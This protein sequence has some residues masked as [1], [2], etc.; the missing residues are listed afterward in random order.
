MRWII[1]LRHKDFVKPDLMVY[2]APESNL[3]TPCPTNAI[4]LGAFSS[5][6]LPLPTKLNK[7]PGA[8]VLFSLADDE[9][10]DVPNRFNSTLQPT[11]DSWASIQSRSMESPETDL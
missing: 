11:D 1:R 4:L 6:P 7:S 9:I 8:L 2:W 10:V 5:P 3:T